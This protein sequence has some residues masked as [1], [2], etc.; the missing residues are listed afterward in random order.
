VT[1]PL[2]L[3]ATDQAALVAAGEVSA[4]ELDALARE[5]LAER[6]PALNAVIHVLAPRPALP[7]PFHGVPLVLKDL[8]APLAGA[9]YHQGM[10]VLRDAGHRAPRSSWLTESFLHAGFDVIGRTNTPELGSVPTTEPVAYGATR[11]PW[12]PGRSSGGSSG[13]SAAAVAARIV[14]VAHANDGG[15][16]IRIPAACCGLVG[17]K[18]S[19]G[20]VSAGPDGGGGWA[21]LA[22][23]GVVT[24]SVRDTAAVLDR[25]AGRRPGDPYAAAPPARPF[26]AAIG[27]PGPRLRVGLCPSMPGVVVQ[28]EVAE[29][30][31]AA[32]R[33]LEAAGHHVE[34]AHPA[35]LTDERELMGQALGTI[36]AAATAADLDAIGR[37][38]GRPLTADDVE[39]VNWRA[40]EA[41]RRL[42]APAYVAA[43]TE[44]AGYCRRVAAWWG[45]HDV[46]VT[47]TMPHVAP[48]L[49][50]Y[51][52]DG[53]PGSRHPHRGRHRVHWA[54]QRDRPTGDLAAARVDRR[55]S[56]R[57]RAARR[58]RRPRGRPA[59]PRRP[60]RTGPAVGRPGAAH[61]GVTCEDRSMEQLGGKVA[62]VTGAGS[63]IGR[64]VATAC[65]TEGM[66]VALADVQPDALDA[67]VTALADDG[68]D[69]LGVR[70]DVSKEADVVALRDAA[71]ARFGTVHLVHNNAGVVAAGPIESLDQ[72]TWDWV[73]GVDLWSVI[74]GI[75]AFLP[76]LTAQGE[77]HVV[78]TASTAGLAA[79]AG[80]APY[81]V[82]KFGVVAATETLAL[83]LR[84]TGS[85][86]GCSVLCPGAVNTQIVHATR[87]M[88][89]D[90]AA[91]YDGGAVQERFVASAGNMLATKGKD[92]AE[93]AAMVLDAVRT[94]RFWIVTHPAWFDVLEARV[95]AMREGRLHVGF[96]G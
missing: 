53:T 79:N 25:L 64:A 7:G 60:P 12:D 59:G 22:A 75:R 3:D 52:G 62:V 44:L 76:V 57:R 39:W 77:G 32:G 68:H 84:Q 91:G 30:V 28:A 14:A 43:L 85:P 33:A 29:A 67:A 13:G 38:V 83:E 46:L 40:A 93:V 37:L 17:L 2:D 94:G 48:P 73:L 41:G 69:V 10:R 9:P 51:A 20:R 1:H 16:S 27:G 23:E 47:P 50:W 82:A 81:N 35:A 24:R 96:G 31:E 86:V 15:G 8:N 92:P 88:P 26:V 65:A 5:R 21:G 78:N 89:T 63:G 66:K 61:G 54:V 71:V 42:P 90:V 34:L 72:A 87:N 70:T 80:I 18:P 56:A 55:R 74:Y 36:V 19:R 11:N 49:G 95:A 6:N 45:D 4:A 58:R